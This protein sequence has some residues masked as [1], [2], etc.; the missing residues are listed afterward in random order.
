MPAPTT[1]APSFA[2]RSRAISDAD[3]SMRRKLTRTTL[4]GSVFAAVVVGWS[5]L[6]QLEGAVIASAAVK[7]EGSTRKI[8][9]PFS[10]VIGRINVKEG[11]RVESGAIVVA[12]DDTVAKANLGIIMKDLV[13]FHVRLARLKAERDGTSTLQIPT[14]IRP[15]AEAD[16]V[17]LEQKFLAD[18][19]ET[20]EGQKLQLRKR[21]QQSEEETRGYEQQLVWIR[22]QMESLQAEVTRLKPLQDSGTVSLPRLAQPE[23][24]LMRYQEREAEIVARIAQTRGR[25]QEVES[26]ILQIDRDLQ[27]EISKETRE[28]ETEIA[29]LNERRIAA[30]DQLRK[31]DVRAP[32]SGRVHQLAVH[33]SG[34]GFV[35]PGD[36][37]MEIVPEGDT[38]IAEG[39]VSPTDIDQLV[40]GQQTRIRFSAFSQNLTPE[41]N[42]EVFRIGADAMRDQTSGVTFYTVGVRFSEPDLAQLVQRMRSA[43]PPIDFKLVPGMPAE[44]FIRTRPRTFA[45]Y[46]LKPLWDQIERVGKSD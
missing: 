35:N 32:I 11:E 8:Q 7:V 46:L 15:L 45:S 22:R 5:T 13:A 17:R 28:A 41:V 30:D 39:R 34:A 1:T 29:K 9:A 10:G 12:L 42:G 23:R 4:Y 38:L 33:T 25:I 43:S 44:V 36:T 19:A 3:D 16:M 37:L 21:I 18:R 26:Q 6:M 40:L 24:D 2:E 31:I 14:D 20:R 27:T